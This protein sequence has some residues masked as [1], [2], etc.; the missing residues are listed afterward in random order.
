MAGGGCVGDL[1]E[2]PQEFPEVSGFMTDEPTTAQ[3][4][5]NLSFHAS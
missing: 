5:I 4:Y 1:G 2:E 3:T